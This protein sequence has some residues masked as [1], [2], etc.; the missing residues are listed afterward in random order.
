MFQN[1]SKDY[2]E[3]QFEDVKLNKKDNIKNI[4]KGLLAKQN[5]V[6]YILTFM[7]SM[8]GF[9]SNNLIFSIVPFGL[10]LLAAAFSNGQAIGIMYILSLIGTFIRFGTNNLLTYV[11]TSLTFFILVLLIRP[12]IQEGV[13]EKRKIGVHLFFAVF[14]VQVVPLFFRTFYVFDL[15]TSIMLGMTTY[16]FYKIFVSS[17]S[18]IKE[19]GTKKAFTIEEVMGT[20]LLIAIAISAFGDLNIFGFSIKNILS[21]LIVLIL[22]WKNG[23]LVGATGGITIGVVLGIIGGSEPVMIAVYAVSGMIAGLLNRFGRI[24]VIVGFILGN[25]VIAYAANGNSVPLIMFQEILIASLGLLAIP[26]RIHINIEDLFGTTKLLPETT[27]RSLEEN[28]DTVYKLNSISETI[29]DMA[30]SYQEAAATILSEEELKQQERSN[31][32]IFM[33]EFKNNLDG[34][35]DNMLYDT[36]CYISEEFMMDIFEILL[37]KDIITEK[38]FINVLAKHNQYIVGF[39]DTSKKAQEDVY[40]IVKALNYSYRVSKLSFIWKK[41]MD[42]SK[43][44]VSAGL[45][46]VSE[47]ISKMAVEIDKKEEDSFADE[48]EEIIKLLEQKET[49]IKDINIKRA[50]SGRYTVNVY[51]DICENVDGT[52]CDIKKIGK[53]VSKVLNEKMIIQ[54]QECGLRI[55][56]KECKFTYL[57]EDKYKVQV[58]IAKSTKAG[59]PVS[60]DSSIHIKL[61]DGK[62]LLAL[63]DGKGSGPEA[64]KSSKIAIKMLERLLTAGFEKDVSMKLIN[65]T[66]SANT[67]EDMFA[68]LDI[69]I[70]D[71]FNGNME[72]I[73]NSACPTYIKRNGDVQLLKAVSLP[74]GILTNVDLVVYDYD[75]QDGDILV[76]C[77]DGII[78]SNKEYLNKQVWLKYLLEDIQIDDAQKI[79]DIIIGEAIDND[80]GVQKDDMTV[81]VAK[82]TKK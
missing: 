51:T 6:L 68:T 13:N 76:M 11:V 29:F 49:F 40:K 64:M 58:G 30:E 8:V 56:K 32:E 72:F 62:Y 73:K 65:S 2:A 27:G 77:S 39:E 61:N 35:E 55:N 12:K 46:G 57:S 24:G 43:K 26:K 18:L 23:I 66:L 31:I 44:N 53:I 19:F 22:G 17:I 74:T 10:A 41:K 9:S 52:Q 25:V 47:A 42:E 4:A 75:L 82:I 5:L 70:L 16:I 67:S 63:S 33:E 71:L 48:K 81:I 28:K 50:N 15:L 21:I 69:Q 36:M 7:V 54:D 38:D 37:E 78:D 34:L 45:K 79:A 20:S 3:D 1:I 59:S 14:L 80:F 60:G